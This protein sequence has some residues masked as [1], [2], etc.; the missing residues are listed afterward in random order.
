MLTVTSVSLTNPSVV[1][2]SSTA[3]TLPNA[4]SLSCAVTVATFLFTV[5]SKLVVASTY[6]FAVAFTYTVYTPASFTSGN[7]SLQSVPSFVV[8]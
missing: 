5:I 6:S 8:L 1:Y 2:V 3:S 7:V 4:A